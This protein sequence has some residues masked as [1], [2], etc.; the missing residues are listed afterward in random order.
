[1]DIM[2]NRRPLWSR[3]MYCFVF[4][5]ALL[6]VASSNATY[7]LAQLPGGQTT[8]PVHPGDRVEVL[9]LHEWVSGKVV[10]YA[11]G[12]VQV[13]VGQDG[14]TYTRRFRL[15]TINYPNG[16]GPWAIWTTK[17]SAAIEG[18]YVSRDESSVTIRLADGTQSTLN[19][20]DLTADLKKAIKQTP[21]TGEENKVNGVEPIRVGDQVLARSSS[22][23]R[24]RG[25]VKSLRIQHAEVEYKERDKLKSRWF[26]FEDIQFANGEGEWRTWSDRTEKFKIV[27][28]FISRTESEVT[29]RKE[30]QSEISIPINRLSSTLKKWVNSQP[31]K[32]EELIVNGVNPWRVGDTVEAFTRVGS[33]DTG[34]IKEIRA[35]DCLIEFE[36]GKRTRETAITHDLIRY[37]NQEGHWQK[38]TDQSKSF[39]VIARYLWRDPTHVTLLRENNKEIRVP[40]ERLSDKLQAML[41]ERISITPRPEKIEFT[42]APELAQD[43]SELPSFEKLQLADSKSVL[44]L[45][46]QPGGFGFELTH[47]DSIS[48]AIV[49]GDPQGWIAVGTYG[50]K[51]LST[52]R[53]TRLYWT[54]PAEQK[55]VPGPSFDGNERILDYSATQK[56]LITVRVSQDG[57][58]DRAQEYCSYRLDVGEKYA[59]PEYRW[60]SPRASNLVGDKTSWKAQLVNDHQLLI[61]DG[62]LISLFDF[63]TRGIVYRLDS[64]RHNHFLLHPSGKYVLFANRFYEFILI[65]TTT[66][67]KIAQQKAAG[68]GRFYEVTSPDGETTTKE[69]TLTMRTVYAGFSPDGRLL[70]SANTS[71]VRTWDL[72]NNAPARVLKT[73]NLKGAAKPS[74]SVLND[75]WIWVN[76]SL[77]SIEKEIVAWSYRGSGVRMELDEVHGN[78]AVLAAIG[79]A[80]S[81]K[82]MAYIG[83]AEIPHKLAR[84]TIKGLDVEKMLMCKPGIGI[85]IEAEGDP[86]VKAG[87]MR[88]LKTNDWVEDPESDLVLSG[89]AVRGERVTKTHAKAPYV[90][91]T[92]PNFKKTFT[93]TIEPWIQV[94]ELKFRDRSVWRKISGGFPTTFSPT[95]TQANYQKRADDLNIESYDLFEHATPKATMYYPQFKYG[96]GE[97][98]ITPNGFVDQVNKFP[99][100]KP[101]D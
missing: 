36:V 101:E 74:V 42:P 44:P 52:D 4:S 53:V 69:S 31:I 92:D 76:S 39:E 13:E 2:S 89:S 67:K 26:K 41:A 15:E 6:S 65:E 43:T 83:I 77:Y 48:A 23:S 71:D 14:D 7:C 96:L 59:K 98:L 54:L 86:R 34:T 3:C 46:G 57:Q 30:D 64:E 19:I 32:G 70:A 22:T 28:R 29:L 1:M 47:G 9:N 33:I 88:I 100:E 99:T 79:P 95:E 21:L 45:P 12:W 40:I 17:K 24:Q 5:I 94:I 75:R 91:S 93:I 58:F 80:A 50:S 38:W 73:R 37:P 82:A 55:M 18:K 84:E 16:E 11:D 68:S 97:S 85:R 78:K 49:T 25:I 72:A 35:Q 62:K 60:E 8:D 63:N 66:G 81:A 61:A 20:N 87:L 51:D 10:S 90:Y 56:R 27:G